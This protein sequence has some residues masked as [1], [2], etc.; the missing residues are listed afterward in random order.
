MANVSQHECDLTGWDTNILPERP[1]A[2]ATV[3]PERSRELFVGEDESGR[4]RKK[5]RK[6]L[7]E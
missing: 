6:T 2:P 5:P 3:K 7:E 4:N 1:R